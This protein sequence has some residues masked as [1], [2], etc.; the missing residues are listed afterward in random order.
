MS[1]CHRRLLLAARSHLSILIFSQP[2]KQ[3]A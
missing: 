2:E 3:P 1:F